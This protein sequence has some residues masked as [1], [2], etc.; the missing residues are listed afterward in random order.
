MLNGGCPFSSTAAVKQSP[1]SIFQL[2]IFVII[3]VDDRFVFERFQEIHDEVLTVPAEISVQVESTSYILYILDIPRSNV[4]EIEH[5][6]VG[7]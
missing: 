2:L 4:S 1:E 6:L 3:G 7:S 5:P